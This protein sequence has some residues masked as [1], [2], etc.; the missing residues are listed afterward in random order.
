MPV[1]TSKKIGTSRE[2]ART[3]LA[4]YMATEGQDSDE[5]AAAGD[6]IADL[7]HLADALGSGPPP[8]AEDSWGEYAARVA[9]EHGYRPERDD[10]AESW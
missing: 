2:N 6:L 9:L 10:E 7:C 1:R 8:F 3:A 4:A 5:L